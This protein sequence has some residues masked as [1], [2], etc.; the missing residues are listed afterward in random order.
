MPK[1]P[2]KGFRSSL[3]ASTLALLMLMAVLLAGN[4][5][6]KA[7]EGEGKYSFDDELCYDVSSE[8]DFDNTWQV[9]TATGTGG[10]FYAY[11]ELLVPDVNNEK[12][13]TQSTAL[14]GTVGEY[15]VSKTTPNPGDT[16][17]P[18]AGKKY[19]VAFL[20][21]FT[22]KKI[23]DLD[24]VRIDI[25]LNIAGVSF[26]TMD[27]RL[28]DESSSSTVFSGKDI[29]I[30]NLTSI[31][32]EVNDL[33]TINTFNTNDKIQIAFDTAPGEFIPGNTFVVFDLQFY[34]IKEV[35][36]PSLTA[37]G[38]WMGAGG[39][40]YIFLALVVSPEYTIEGVINR[41]VTLSSGGKK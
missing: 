11:W 38:L 22:K 29:S 41:F 7:R 1:K 40:F 2:V 30:G 23:I 18:S 10:M 17:T 32:V 8:K 5:I 35:K 21:N 12:V 25:Y 24:I 9:G 14:N 34:C 31:K 33:L 37:L 36:I 4:S 19:T 13:T 28:T 16:P 15:A 27:L 3:V 20:L 39:L 6:Q 26:S